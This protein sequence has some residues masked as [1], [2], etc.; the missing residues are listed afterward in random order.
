M[1][2]IGIHIINAIPPD[3]KLTHNW[4]LFSAVLLSGW[5][6]VEIIIRVLDWITRS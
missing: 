5:A 3:R 4:Y 2:T 1:R 6:S